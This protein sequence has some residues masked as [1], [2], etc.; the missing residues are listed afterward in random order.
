MA[1]HKI[2]PGGVH[3]NDGK[4]LA[5]DEAIKVAPLLK[6]YVVPLSQHIGAP[7]KLIVA[8]G[9]K[10]LKGQK[11]AEAGGFVSV[12][13]HAPTSGEITSIGKS[14]ITGE[15]T[16]VTNCIGPTGTLM[17]S[18]TITADGEDKEGYELEPMTNWREVSGDDLKKRCCEAG[19]VG[20]GGA[21]FPSHVKLS[22]PPE[23][24]IKYL[25]LNGAECEPYLTADHRL[26]LEE[27]EKM[28]EGILMMKKILGV[29]KVI[30]GIEN[31][32]PDAIAHMK[33]VAKEGI[34]VKGLRVMYPQGSEKQLIYALTG[35][36]VPTGGLPME[37]GCVV[38]NVGTAVA[39]CEAVVDGKPLFERITTITGDPIVKPG[40]WKLRIGSPIGE[41]LKLAGGVKDPNDVGKILLGG[42]M[43]GM[44]QFSLEVPIM[45]NASGLLLLTRAQVSQ[46]TS[47]PCIRCG[48][49]V[50]V[51]PMN[52]MPAT[53]SVQAEKERFELCEEW[54]VMDCVECGC[55]A[56]VCPSHR[57][58]VQLYR[59]AKAVINQERR[60]AATAKK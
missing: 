8:K 6:E 26:M 21:A 41:V 11:I 19:I 55:C 10:V 9:D 23:K 38:Q 14:Q 46:Y 48:K 20:L 27:A 39:L 45:K 4:S 54:N 16:A 30:I 31:N 53:M 60:K 3:P 15:M 25:I 35:E 56:F 18:V 49:C 1:D 24:N 43:M 40:N 37:A 34:E 28:I 7:A 22:P 59:R 13:I 33:T 47:G 2:F 36:K 17:A 42:P 12:P 58:L 57:P 44:A 50:D 52:L 51:C 32:K 5:K 29:E